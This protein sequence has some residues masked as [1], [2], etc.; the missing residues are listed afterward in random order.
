MSDS[1]HALG[2]AARRAFLRQ[3]GALAAMLPLLG[4]PA[5]GRALAAPLRPSSSPLL[6]PA[7]ALRMRY[8]SPAS[9]ADLLRQGLPIGN[10]RLGALVG[11]APE[12][13]VLYLSDASLWTGGRNDV[14]DAQGQFPY[15]KDSFGSFVMLAKL[16]LELD[17]HAPAQLRDYARELDLS[18][19][20]MRARYTLGAARFTRT[21]FASHPDDAIVIQLEQRGGGLHSG[22]L[23]LVSAH[24]APVQGDAGGQ[25]G[26]SGTLANG[27]RHGASVQL[28]AADG[29]VELRG[30]TLHFRDCS[31]LRIIV[32]GGS[33]YVPDL[34][35][36]YRDPHLDPRAL[37]R[38]RCAAAAAL[39]PEALLYTHVADHRALFDSMQVEL[40]RSSAAQRKLDLWERLQARAAADTPDPELEALYLQF[41]RYLTVAA[42]RDALPINLQGLWLENNDPPWMS[43][44]HSDVNLQMNYWLTDAAGLSPCFDALARYCLAQ[45]P[46][47]TQITQAHFNDPRNRFRNT[48]GKVAGWAVAF[49]TNPFGGSGWSWHPGGNAWLCDSLW[50]HYEYTQ[51]RAYLARIYPLLKGACEFWQARLIALE[52]P[53][54]DG[55]P[56]TRLVD[57][58]DW[59]PEHGPEDA[60]GIAYAQELAWNLF[61]Q[62]RQASALLERDAAYAT[63]IAELQQRLYLPQISPRSGQLQEWMSPEDLGE[64]HHRHLSPLIG[65]YPGHRLHPD[66]AQSEQVAAARK[67]LEARGM[68]S[69]GW[70]CAWRALCWA[71]LGEA[72]RAYALVA[73]NLKPSIVHSNGTAPNFFDIYDLSQHGDPT[74]GGVFQIDANFGTPTAMLEMLLYSRPG[75]IALLPALPKAWAEH[76]RVSGIGA[77]GGFVVDLEWRAGKATRI[78][79]RSVGG[80]RTELAFNGTRRMVELA[81]GATMRAL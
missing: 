78:A 1:E 33:N 20:C 46:A 65:L 37:A 61:G 51:D 26:F 7:Q 23:R 34:A 32:C 10:G 60:R 13:D 50:Q 79:L 62:Y 67:L 36:N 38:Q 59:S 58:H 69:F 55:R 81:H 39:A 68:H 54:P 52:V 64:P 76:G 12:R 8:A 71:R 11:G 28:V 17:G 63:T 5:F 45:L 42:S 30:D 19:G 73:T 75:H 44:Y 49:S 15:D 70:A 77:R 43:D 47:W 29:S 18:N 21:V 53:G 74:L 48:S 16:Y 6:P 14:L 4:L 3:G 41:G 40:G 80:T 66:L 27:L 56:H 9:E 31:A 35:R 25:L 2:N 57:D 72:E 24:A 22:R